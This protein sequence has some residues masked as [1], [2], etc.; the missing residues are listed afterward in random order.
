MFLAMTYRRRRAKLTNR[1][2]VHSCLA[3]VIEFK[4]G[5]VAKTGTKLSV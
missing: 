1:K 2:I 3:T 4:T 5:I